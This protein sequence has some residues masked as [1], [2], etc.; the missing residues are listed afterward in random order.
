MESKELKRA[1]ELLEKCLPYVYEHRNRS[2]QDSLTL[3]NIGNFLKRN[4]PDNDD[5]N[6]IADAG[7]MVSLRDQF[8]MAALQGIMANPSGPI[9]SNGMSGWGWCN[10]SP[11]DVTNLVYSVA[12]AMLKE[13]SK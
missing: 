6:H 3:K 8:A 12:D 9:Q 1:I 4:Q 5:Q 2:Y 7:K 11:S 13:R 10:C